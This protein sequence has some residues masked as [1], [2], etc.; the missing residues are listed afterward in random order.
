MN[1]S[2]SA[3]IRSKWKTGE[4]GEKKLCPRITRIT[5]RETL[6]FRM[7]LENIRANS[8]LPGR[9]LSEAGDSRATLRYR[10]S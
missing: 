5:R 7:N 2:G 6:K 9:S 1:Q 4:T 3:I 8:R 10:K